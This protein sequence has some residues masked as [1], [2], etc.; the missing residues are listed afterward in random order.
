MRLPQHEGPYPVNKPCLLTK[1]VTVTSAFTATSRT[2]PVLASKPEGTSIES[3]GKFEQLILR[4][5]HLY[6][7]LSFPRK[8]IPISASTITSVSII[9]SPENIFTSTFLVSANS[10]ARATFEQN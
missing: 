10:L 1:K 8:P 5:A 3:V 9:S 4:I 6:F 2:P 7:S